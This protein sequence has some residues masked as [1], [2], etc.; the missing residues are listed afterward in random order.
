[1]LKLYN[2]VPERAADEGKLNPLRVGVAALAM[3][4]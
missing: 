1:M 3:A 2:E 4:D